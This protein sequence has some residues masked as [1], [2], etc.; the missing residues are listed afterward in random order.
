MS[1][2]LY[3]L[4]RAAFRRRRIVVLAWLL[5]L[6][7]GFTLMGTLSKGT[8]DTVRIPGAS[9]QSA[10][11]TLSRVFPQVS[12][13]S[14]MIVVVVP[15]GASVRSQ[16]ERDAIGATVDQIDALGQVATVASPFSPLVSGAISA[17]D[18]AAIITIQFDGQRNELTEQTLDSVRQ[19]ADEL[20]SR[21]GDGARVDVGGTAFDNVIPTISVVEA[22][23]V[24]LALVFLAVFLRNVLAAFVPIVMALVGVAI[25]ESLVYAAT[26]FMTIMSTT[27]LLSVMI[28]LAVGIDYSLFIISRYRDNLAQGLEPEEAVARSIATAGTAVVFAGVTVIIALVGLFVARIPFLTIMGVA[29]AFGVGTAVCVAMTLLPATLGFFGTRI[30]P[31]PGRRRAGGDTFFG[32]W[33]RVVTVRPLVTVVLVIAAVTV[34]ALPARGLRLSPPM[35]SAAKPG[36]EV[37]T[38]YDTVSEKFGPGYN[39][40][41]IVVVN[42]LD[43]TDPVQAMTDLGEDLA[44]VEG[45]QRIAMATPN[46]SGSYGIVQVIPTGSPDSAA[47]AELVQALRAQGPAMAERYGLRDFAVTGITA[48]AVDVS[49]KLT[50][51]LV[52]YGVFVVGLSLVL[53]VMVFGSIAVPIKATVGY[54]LSILAS[55]GVTTSIFVD[56]HLARLLGADFTGSLICFLPII[57]MGVLFGLAMDYEVFL[58]SRTA[59]EYAH[60]GDPVQAIHE[61]FCKAAPVVTTAALIML[62]VFAMFIPEG[63]SGIIK[64]IAT[65]LTVGVFVDAFCVRMTLVP[66][67]LRLLGHRAWTM[68]E[69]LARVLP[70]FDVE[71]A[72]LTRQLSLEGWPADGREVVA[73]KDMIVRDRDGAALN[74]P[75]DLDLRPGQIA[76][77][78]GPEGSGKSELLLGLTGRLTGFDGDARVAGYLLP[79]RNAAVRSRS[80]LTSGGRD[81][82][83]VL[84]E[85]LHR[86]V[87][88][89]A[90]DDADAVIGTNRTAEVR[91]LI[92]RLAAAGGCVLL[93][94]T[95]PDAVAHVL[96]DGTAPLRI[97]MEPPAPARFVPDGPQRADGQS[98]PLSTILEE[99]SR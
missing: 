87:A 61:G 89:A 69:R 17:D 96:P 62:S 5:V 24:V 6:V 44:T 77:L 83:G 21:L 45:V 38:T 43:S 30:T 73:T 68:P 46:E 2:H 71:G 8:D 36:S 40:P 47:T 56:G 34:L 23:G 12:G 11:D 63:S 50:H 55:F 14:G 39:G 25:T 91:D 9:S 57:V 82:I 72:S 81:V 41:L 18:T 98:A 32:H 65:A 95:S 1:S 86:H 70:R 7:A 13:A 19:A 76:V 78:T 74:R 15:D 10:L 4:G 84:A 28:G 20:Q 35:E 37:R 75:V 31:R 16:P 60:S 97:A 26:G 49:A 67:V 52:P 3:R 33:V 42:V 79:E 66:A 51:A 93:T 80:V 88:L 29:S 27:V 53:L 90:V 54:L 48:V 59:E 64:P 85:G 58:V 99:A 92:G 22:I 94:G